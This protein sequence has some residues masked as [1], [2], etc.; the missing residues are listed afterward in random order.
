METTETKDHEME[1]T[2]TSEHIIGRDAVAKA[3]ASAFAEM[4]N[5]EPQPAWFQ[6]QQLGCFI[7]DNPVDVR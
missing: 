6:P 4:S 1:T 7:V 2:K 5:R 3:V